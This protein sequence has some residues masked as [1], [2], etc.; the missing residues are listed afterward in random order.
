[1]FT[2][3]ELDVATVRAAWQRAGFVHVRGVLEPSVTEALAASVDA[4]AERT[5]ARSPD[6][7]L[8]DQGAASVRMKNI[9]EQSADFDSLIV[10]PRVIE[11]LEW[12]MGRWFKLL[13]SEA[14]TRVAE[15]EFLLPFHTDGGPL[16]QRVVPTAESDAIQVK[17][18]FFL[19][20]ADMPDVGQL[21]VI[22]GSH[23]RIPAVAEPNCYVEEANSYVRDN[24]MPPGAVPVPARAGDITIHTHSLWHGVGPNPSG[25]TRRS[26]ILRYGQPWCAAHDYERYEREV[27]R[28]FPEPNWRHLGYVEE[29]AD[30][31]DVYKPREGQV[32]AQ[33]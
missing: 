18:Q 4:L 23:L 27:L 32:T 17:V 21:I 24:S 5:R 29:G 33:T 31:A 25:A 7:P 12:F 10:H 6:R 13:G 16:L 28:R 15:T 19:T 1:M 30:P 9:I 20:D 26:V 8:S 11:I 22:P 3:E 14:F 2:L